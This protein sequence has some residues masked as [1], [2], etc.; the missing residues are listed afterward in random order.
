MTILLPP[1]TRETLT[2]RC[3]TVSNWLIL[4]LVYTDVSEVYNFASDR[5]VRHPIPFAYQREV[6]DVLAICYRLHLETPNNKDK[7]QV[8]WLRTSSLVKSEFY[9]T[10]TNGS[11]QDVLT[12]YTIVFNA[13][14]HIRYGIT[15]CLGVEI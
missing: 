9:S 7:N 3:Y 1:Q 5:Y 15:V 2:Q 13:K 14:S 8:C 10:T 12:T 6:N 11:T 4:L